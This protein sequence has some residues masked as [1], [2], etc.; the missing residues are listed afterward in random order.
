MGPIPDRFLPLRGRRNIVVTRNAKRYGDGAEP[1]GSLE[2]ALD[3][4]GDATEVHDRRRRDLRGRF[5]FAD[6]LL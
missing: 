4:A 1:A 6:E 5:P 2:E 3:L